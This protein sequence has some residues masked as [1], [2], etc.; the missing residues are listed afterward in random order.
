MSKAPEFALE[1]LKGRRYAVFATTD[2]DGTIHTTP[3]WYLFEEGKFYVSTS[4]SS[5]KARNALARPNAT[6][7][8]DVREPGRE[9][10]VSAAGQVEIIRGGQ[11]NAINLKVVSR[12]LTEEAMADSRIGPVFANPE[13]I[14]MCLE[15]ETWRS[16]R[17]TELDDKYFGGILG[18]TPEK[19]FRPVEI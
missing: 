14:T 12:Y 11:S 15:P 6:I 7:L 1:I 17:S 3:V 2:D 8:V 10:W 16:F 18:K 9:I 13:E 19:W 5:R 4:P